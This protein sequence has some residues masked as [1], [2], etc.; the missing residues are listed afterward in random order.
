MMENKIPFTLKYS[1]YFLSPFFYIKEDIK[2]LSPKQRSILNKTL[3][4]ILG[5]TYK[6]SLIDKI[7]KLDDKIYM[8]KSDENITDEV[9]KI[10][11]RTYGIYYI[12]YIKKIYFKYITSD[13]LKTAMQ[14]I[15]IIKKIIY[16][17]LNSKTIKEE[18]ILHLIKINDSN[19]IP[20]NF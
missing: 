5:K 4:F 9:T 10:V 1:Y 16:S 12:F 8:I 20:F 15:G 19:I 3:D 13:F 14:N 11:N 17:T 18:T 7:K 2:S 6:K